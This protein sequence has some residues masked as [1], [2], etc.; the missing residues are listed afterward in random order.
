MIEQLTLSFQETTNIHGK[1][2]SLLATVYCLLIY[3]VSLSLIHL[4][5]SAPTHIHPNIL[6][7]SLDFWHEAQ[8]IDKIE[9]QISQKH[10]EFTWW[11]SWGGKEGQKTSKHRAVTLLSFKNTF[12]LYQE[13]E[14]EKCCRSDLCFPYFS[15]DLSPKG[16]VR[17]TTWWSRAWAS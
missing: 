12:L 1:R 8:L 13:K 5:L 14:W 17:K 11:K 7:F 3:P 10:V 4:L 2:K 15:Q 6:I 16:Y 9:S